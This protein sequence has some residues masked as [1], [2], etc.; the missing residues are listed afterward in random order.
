MAKVSLLSINVAM[1]IYLRY[2]VSGK[3]AQDKNETEKD[4][5]KVKTKKITK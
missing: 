2:L 5:S 1:E 4:S 3:N